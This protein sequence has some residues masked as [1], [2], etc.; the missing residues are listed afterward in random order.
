ME[1]SN[2]LAFVLVMM[3]VVLTA[4]MPR[5]A[6]AARNEAMVL[7][8]GNNPIGASVNSTSI[9]TKNALANAFDAGPSSQKREKMHP[10]KQVVRVSRGV[11]LWQLPLFWSVH[12]VLRKQGSWTELYDVFLFSRVFV[13]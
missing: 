9:N 7:A 1:P 12:V 11:L 3:A 13:S 8:A 10:S 4:T 5:T 6:T 2:K